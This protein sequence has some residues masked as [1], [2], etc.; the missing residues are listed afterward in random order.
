MFQT[1]A[2]MYYIANE[3]ISVI[4]NTSLMGVPYPGFIKKALEVLKQRGEEA[5]EKE[6]PVNHDDEEDE[7]DND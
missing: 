7:N 6:L 1:A 4:E 5:G 2:T 3:G